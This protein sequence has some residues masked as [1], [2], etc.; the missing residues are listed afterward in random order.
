MT[1]AFIQSAG[2]GLGA[3]IVNILASRPDIGHLFVSA[4]RMD[5]HPHLK[6][7]E[8]NDPRITAVEL[9]LL[10]ES[11][12]E[13]AAQRVSATTDR[14]HLLLTTAG[15]LHEPGGMQPERA[16]AH[17]DPENLMRAFAVNATGPLLMAKH[18]LPLLR[19]P[20]RA[21]VGTV[22]ARVGSISDNRRGGWYA[23]RASKAAQNM[24][25]KT[26]SIEL[27]NRAPNVIV[28]ALHPG[29]VDTPLSKP[30]QRNVPPKQL[31]SAE[32]AAAHML[33]VIASLSPKDTGGFFAW[34]GSPIPW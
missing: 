20:D 6:R 10:D 19:H 16:L 25:T 32:R 5:D 17:V 1:N 4:R 26:L 23:Y 3:A 18:F 24:I 9:E 14:L 2:G 34:D 30:F 22:S 27:A 12:I 31:F 7:L 29:T 28:A 33:D 15:L 11:S 8:A 13:R 21:V